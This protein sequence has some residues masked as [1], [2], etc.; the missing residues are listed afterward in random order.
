[1][2]TAMKFYGLLSMTFLVLSQT[3]YLFKIE[4]DICEHLECRNCQFKGGHSMAETS[5][6]SKRVSLFVFSHM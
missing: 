2:L 5:S 1:M 4:N 6:R 3:G